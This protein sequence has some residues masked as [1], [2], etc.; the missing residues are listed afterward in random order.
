[1]SHRRRKRYRDRDDIRVIRIRSK[2]K[3]DICNIL[4]LVDKS[5]VLTKYK[6]N[7]FNQHAELTI[8]EI[9]SNHWSEM[10]SIYLKESDEIFIYHYSY[11]SWITKYETF[12]IP[13]QDIMLWSFMSEIEYQTIE[14]TI[15]HLLDNFDFYNSSFDDTMK[16]KMRLCMVENYMKHIKEDKLERDFFHYLINQCSTK[17]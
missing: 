16:E 2:S 6:I 4:R 12:D 14:Q 10:P 8:H 7:E 5:H 3:E 11:I 9:G 15:E 17:L 13:S 1:M